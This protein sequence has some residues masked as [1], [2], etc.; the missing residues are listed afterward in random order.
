MV[1]DKG[2]VENIVRAKGLGAKVTEAKGYKE[3][4]VRTKGYVH[5][6]KS[7]VRCAES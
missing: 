1:Q 6:A 5:F 3:N 4:V 2:Y 7:H